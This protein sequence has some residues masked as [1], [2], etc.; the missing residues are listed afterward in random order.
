M[1]AVEIKKLSL[2]LETRSSK[3]NI[4]NGV[5]VSINKGETVSIVGPSGAGKTSLL[6]L[7]SGLEK[8]TSGRIYIN[9]I[10]ITFYNEDELAVFRRDHIGIIFQNFYLIPTMT[11][12]ENVAIPLEFAG[13]ENAFEKAKDALKE[14]GLSHRLD[15]FPS[16][17]SGGEQQR[18]GIARAFAP[19]P[20]LILADELT[21]NLD[22]EN[23][24][25]IID[26]LFAMNKKRKTTLVLITH[27]IKLANL[28]KKH[29]RILDGEVSTHNK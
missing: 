23:G 12:L 25:K 1:K 13:V 29:I 14:V 19:N 22:S 21:G 7:I 5:S 10:D 3:I 28:C 26:M 4:L 2:T 8:P 20:E 9:G 24:K 15:H 11:A 6:M 18:V 16:Q 17:L 27:D